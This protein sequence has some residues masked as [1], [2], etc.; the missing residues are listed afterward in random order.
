MNNIKKNL[1]Y[2]ICATFGLFNFIL[3]AIPYLALS[4]GYGNISGYECMN[5]W[6]AAL[7]GAMISFLQILILL[8]GCLLIVLGTLGILYTFGVFKKFPDKECKKCCNACL[9]ILT[10]LNAL[11]IVFIILLTLNYNVVLSAGVFI[12]TVFSLI[13]TICSASSSKKANKQLTENKDVANE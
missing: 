4:S 12:A 9:I 10:I 7:C 8:L 1:T 2:F 5:L 13:A 11:L 6:N 3:L